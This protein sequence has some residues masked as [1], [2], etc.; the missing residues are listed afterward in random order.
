[1]FYSREFK[2]NCCCISQGVASENSKQIETFHCPAKISIGLLAELTG[3]GCLRQEGRRKSCIFPCREAA[4]AVLGSS[5]RT[6]LNLQ[7]QSF[8][9]P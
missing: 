1:M 2:Y 3:R 7:S 5:H 4:V 9:E 8:L 6:G